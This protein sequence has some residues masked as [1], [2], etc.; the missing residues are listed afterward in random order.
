M[1]K[2]AL[3]FEGDLHDNDADWENVPLFDLDSLPSY[4]DDEAATPLGDEEV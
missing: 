4:G 2:R 1:S 3:P